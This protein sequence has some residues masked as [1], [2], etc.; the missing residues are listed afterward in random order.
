MFWTIVYCVQF[1]EMK[2]A[3]LNFGLL[4]KFSI[5]LRS[6]QNSR[7]GPKYIHTTWYLDTE[8]YYVS[9]TSENVVGVAVRSISI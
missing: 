6:T 9:I 7:F 2:R 5:S 4:C 8:K 1:D 3:L